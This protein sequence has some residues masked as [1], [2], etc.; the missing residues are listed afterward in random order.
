MKVQRLTIDNFLA[1]RHVDLEFPAPVTI[2]LGDNEAGKSSMADA[3]RLALTG[4]PQ[5]VRLKKDLSQL[6]HD[7]ATQGAVVITG[8]GWQA[9]VTVPSGKVT[10]SNLPSG[11]LDSSLCPAHFSRLTADERR[12]FLFR[13]LGVTLDAVTMSAKLEA[14]GFEPKLVA[15][16]AAQFGRVPWPAISKQCSEHATKAKGAWEEVTKE[17]WGERKGETWVPAVPAEPKTGTLNGTRID[18]SKARE[19]FEAKVRHHEALLEQAKRSEEYSVGLRRMQ[20]RAEKLPHA[21]AALATALED[22]EPM[23]ARVERLRAAS[24]S[25]TLCDCPECGAVLRFRAGKLVASGGEQI[26]DS[27][28]EASQKALE[29]LERAIANHTRDRDEARAA[30]KWVEDLQASAALPPPPEDIEAARSAVDE[31]RDVVRSLEAEERAWI[32]A[33]AAVKEADKTRERA[34]QIHRDIVQWIKLADALGPSGLPGEE[35]S[36]VL[37]EF[38]SR[39]AMTSQW[40]GWPAVLVRDD[41]EILIGGRLYGLCSVSA[42]WRADALI[43]EAASFW[44]NRLLVLDGADVLAP[45]SRV[46]LLMLLHRLATSGQLGTVF[47]FATAKEPWTGLPPTMAVHWIEN[48]EIVAAPAK[49]A[50]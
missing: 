16:L 14:R 39:L 47:V 25:G 1:V 20:E 27:D 31:A 45:K 22:M 46:K 29:M 28:L 6:V 5:R 10:S 17:R 35:L 8:E 37:D 30:Q 36:S 21:E 33:A 23:K 7:G 11:E 49:A 44:S 32:A 12:A 24:D 3:I 18:L 38:N 48:G 26:D 34:A 15:Q 9:S 41:M 4:T 50:A 2:I 43:A 19:V 40:A 42:Q 13:V